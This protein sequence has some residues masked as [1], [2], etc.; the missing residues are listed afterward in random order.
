M[1]E[2]PE[3][4]HHPQVE[5]AGVPSGADAM[6]EEPPPEAGPD[7]TQPGGSASVG[8]T[9]PPERQPGEGEMLV[10][11]V[12][13]GASQATPPVE[14]VRRL[15]LI[16]GE[17]SNEVGK[18]IVELFSPPRI[19]EKIDRM[20][21]KKGIVAGTSFDL[22]VD[23]RTGETWNFL[24][25]EDRR[26]CWNRLEEERPWV[27]IGSPPCTAFS[28]INTGLNY[29]K[30][31][32]DE[33]LRR[34]GEARVL[35]G[36]ALAVYH[37]QLNRG[38]Y[39]LHEHPDSASSWELPEVRAMMGRP[40]VQV[41]KTDACVLGMKTVD[42]SGVE[43]PV[44]KPTRWMGN[45]PYLMKELS[46]RCEG[47]HESHVPLMNGRAAGAAIYPPELVAAI[48]RGIQ[49]QVEA[50]TRRSHDDNKNIDL[51]FSPELK[52]AMGLSEEERARPTYDEY[53]GEELPPNLV[54]TGKKEELKYFASKQVWRAVPRPRTPG[55]KVIGTRWV[56]CNKGDS[57]NPDIR[58]RLVCQEMKRYETD[59][60]F[61]ATPPIET[62]RLL[63]SIAAES[64][65][66]VMSLV[67]ISRAYFNANIGREVYVEMPPEAG[68][69]K[70]TVGRLIKCMYGTRDAAQG[71]EATY[72]AALL[73][74]GLSR[75]TANPCLFTHKSRNIRLCVHGDDFL[76]A[77]KLADTKWF[78]AALLKAFE[79]KVKGNLQKP[80]DEIRVLNRI[81]RRTEAGYEMEGDQRHG[82]IIVRDLG[83][84][85]ESKAL[86][87]PGR[88]LT[89]A[90]LDSEPEG[91]SPDDHSDYRARVARC[92]FMASDRFDVAYTVKELCRK[93]SKP[94]TGD[95][96]ALKRLGRYLLDKPRVIIYFPWQ[97]A[98][99]LTVMT[100]SDWAGCPRTRKSTSGGLV[101]RGR[102]LIKHWC[103]TQATVALSSG[104]AELISLV[105]GASEGLGVQSLLRDLGVDSRATILTDASAAIGMCK[106]TGVGKVRHLD[107]RLL[108]IQ[109]KI[110]HGEIGL[111]KIAGLQNPADALT[112]YLGSD[113]LLEH[114]AR[115]GC[116]L[117]EGRARTA[118]ALTKAL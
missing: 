68:M 58:C 22:I 95:Q 33:V 69:P 18:R 75:G 115:A 10:D 20:S 46:R 94:D 99:L 105:R 42:A 70:G 87:V 56:C 27:V 49:P 30:M 37:W 100:D 88:K 106:R 73:R 24:K 4:A 15:C 45:A 102:H 71:W 107:T 86:S 17:T 93:M 80:D 63:V 53:T 13:H 3:G 40:G 32:R 34:Q 64:E 81:I 41:T 92:N 29:P 12:L 66:L 98:E 114:M 31:N 90:E 35:L 5:P 76:S 23:K 11:M 6:E 85:E 61:A 104:E 48:V 113:A 82:E 50:D 112:K 43:G 7:R 55:V 28:T 109:D 47:R 65:D 39:F 9:P 84:T 57:I 8:G 89:K 16:R 96:A 110:R 21:S 19:N 91:L 111:E 67:D 44:K 79:G 36:F 2:E 60:F 14:E 101:M 108:W 103:A 59:E 78:E 74:L 62:M 72:C 77:A 25:P 1:E 51:N 54:A 52:A 83:L 38:C 116:W 117:A 26:R 118:P 97:E